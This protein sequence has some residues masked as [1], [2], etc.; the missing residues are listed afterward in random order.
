MKNKKNNFLL[1]LDLNSLKDFN[2]I[3]KFVK[4][5]YSIKS[6]VYT[7]SGEI[8]FRTLK[9][10]NQNDI[11][12]EINIQ[13]IGLFNLVKTLFEDLKN[14]ECSIVVIGSDVVFGK[15]PIKMLTY[16]VA[17]SSL[18]GITK[19]LAVVSSLKDIYII[20]LIQNI[21]NICV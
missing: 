11:K 15:P 9:D 2:K 14:N 8:E 12:K 1:K 20:W 19:S 4:N 3:K 21:I 18:L 6:I 17:K 16:N 13:T 7:V 10:I 5:K